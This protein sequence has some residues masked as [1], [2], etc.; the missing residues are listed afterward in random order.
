MITAAGLWT[1]DDPEKRAGEA[2]EA[3][4]LRRAAQHP[5]LQEDAPEGRPDPA[6]AVLASAD[7]AEAAPLGSVAFRE[8][9]RRYEDGEITQPVFLVYCAEARKHRGF[10]HLFGYQRGAPDWTRAPCCVWEAFACGLSPND[11][12]DI[13]AIIDMIETF[14]TNGD[15]S[16]IVRIAQQRLDPAAG[17]QIEVD[18]GENVA[19]PD[20]ARR[21]PPAGP[22]CAAAPRSADSRAA[23]TRLPCCSRNRSRATTQ[24]I[25][26]ANR[27]P[28]SK[29]NT[30]FSRAC[31]KP[32]I[33]ASDAI[34]SLA[35]EDFPSPRR[36]A[37]AA[38]V[39]SAVKLSR[40]SK[41][42]SC[43]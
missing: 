21:A 3:F 16:E 9:W 31:A 19:E 42:K 33:R 17:E 39:R 23:R 6:E 34:A 29:R 4:L 13:A 1:P 32:R 8:I 18:A 27:G 5:P 43:S 30:S 14:P 36:R 35:A 10:A 22:S 7:H 38:R 28:I 40:S 2:V 26:Q 20:A 15:Y 24:W 25:S 11:L 12:R 37:L 41:R